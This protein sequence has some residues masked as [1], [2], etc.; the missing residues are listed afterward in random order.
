MD[1][2]ACRLARIGISPHVYV[3]AAGDAG[4]L[5]G[6]LSDL[7][8]NH[9]LSPTS[10]PSEIRAVRQRRELAMD[11]DGIDEAN[12][13]DSS[14]GRRRARRED[15]GGQEEGVGTARK[16]AVAPEAK[17]TVLDESDDEW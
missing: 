8:A 13:M 12:I 5:Y 3:E 15:A 6:L 10:T 11:L 2:L 1:S 16:A 17:G 9:G 7:L 14:P 4:K